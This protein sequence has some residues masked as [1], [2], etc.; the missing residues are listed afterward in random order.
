MT[1][2]PTLTA[3]AFLPLLSG[4]RQLGHDPA[5]LLA[6]VGV[7]PAMLEEP[8]RRIPMSAG[9][10]LLA[11]ASVTTGDDCIGLHL[12]EHAD[13]RTVDVHFYAMAA[14]AT[15][16]SAYE[17]LSRYQRLIHET[18]RIELSDTSDGLTLRHVL[19]GG[20]AAPRQTAE[21]LIAAWV[22]TG[23]LITGTDWSPLE[24]RFAHQEPESTGEHE[25]FFRA[26]LRFS[27]GENAV[28]V[29]HSILSLP[30]SG[31]D[32]VLASFLDRYAREH[33]PSGDSVAPSISDRVRG[34]IEAQL[35]DGEPSAAST[36]AEMRMSVRTLNRALA[37]EHTTYRRV[38]EQLRHELAVR[39]LA[40]ARTSIGEVAFVLGFSELSAFYRAF[41]RWT[42]QTPADFRA[43]AR[44]SDS[45][46]HPSRRSR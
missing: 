16:R 20:F 3:R 1:V 21:F 37:A 6:A 36:A 39:H 13:L 38:L 33:M 40:N 29:A 12:A 8:D 45:S 9:S 43:L 17:R 5:P 34:A 28:V 27:A 18:T 44:S 35:R 24:I 19:P 10:G 14:S 7:A 31:A 4:L 11:R 32:A 42:G 2:E 41:K 46:S 23:R 22:R 30:C 26:P 25:R 15:L